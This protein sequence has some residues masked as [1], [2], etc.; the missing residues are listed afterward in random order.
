LRPYNKKIA[1]LKEQREDHDR[2]SIKHQI[3]GD[4]RAFY[5]IYRETRLK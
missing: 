3:I 4:M 1:K 2:E 5:P